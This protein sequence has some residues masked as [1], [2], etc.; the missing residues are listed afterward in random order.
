MLFPGAWGLKK[1]KK[2]KVLSFV[3][4]PVRGG[5]EKK[6]PAV[7]SRLTG[8]EGKGEGGEGTRLLT[9]MPKRNS[10][11]HQRE[12]KELSSPERVKGKKKRE[13]KG[14]WSLPLLPTKKKGGGETRPCPFPAGRRKEKRKGEKERRFRPRPGSNRRKRGEG[15]RFHHSYEKG[16]GGKVGDGVAIHT[17]LVS[18]CRGK[19]K[20]KSRG[21]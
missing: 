20:R 16:G 1:K 18:P 11:R 17:R 13:G 12:K 2:K 4:T 15:K 7:A 19:G 21:S 10:W 3:I 9:L 6:G 5:K 8:N 14:S